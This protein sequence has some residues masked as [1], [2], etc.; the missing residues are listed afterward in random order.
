MN[1]ISDY[2]YY[3]YYEYYE[4]QSMLLQWWLNVCPV[5]TVSNMLLQW[6]S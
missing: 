3:E 4:W 2:E 6:W 1:A 5:L